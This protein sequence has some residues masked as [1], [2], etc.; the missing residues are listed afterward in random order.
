LLDSETILA[1]SRLSG[2]ECFASFRML[3]VPSGEEAAANSV[4]VND[5]VLVPAGYPATA[6]L[7][8][9]A[10]YAVE[11]VRADQAALLD[12]GL[13]CMSLRFAHRA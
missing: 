1:T 7:I 8:T 4:R 3:T 6:E 13:S 5:K 2:A 11:V 12:G 9:R 10:G